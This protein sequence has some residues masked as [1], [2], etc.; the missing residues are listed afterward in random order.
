LTHEKLFALLVELLGN[1]IKSDD[2]IL[3]VLD[4]LCDV[5]DVFILIR[6]PNVATSNPVDVLTRPRETS[7]ASTQVLI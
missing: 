6:T 3:P 4:L 7:T 1:L 2:I 5:Q